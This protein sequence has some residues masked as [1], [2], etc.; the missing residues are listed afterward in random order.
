MSPATSHFKVD[1][2]L[3]PKYSQAQAWQPEDSILKPRVLKSPHQRF[4]IPKTVHKFAMAALPTYHP[5]SLTVMIGFR[6]LSIVRSIHVKELKQVSIGTRCRLLTA[7]SQS[8]ACPL[9]N[10]RHL[11][12]RLSD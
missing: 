12:V 9:S 6:R 11:T 4:W 7:R 3:K 5:A 1:N 10:Q 2:S 8:I